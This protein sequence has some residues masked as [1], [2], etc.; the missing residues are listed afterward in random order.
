MR[1]INLTP[2]A[3]NLAN[4]EGEIIS[5]IPASG[6]TARIAST[7]T[8][9]GEVNGIPVRRT[10]WGKVEGLPEP[11][12]GVVLVVSTLVAQA[13]HRA[14]VVSPDTGP[15]AVREGGLVKAVRALQAF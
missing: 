14:D 1:F 7:Q 5:T 13:T 4:A 6:Q 15:T 12:D 8:V 2:H 11:Q 10:D 3:I 9:V